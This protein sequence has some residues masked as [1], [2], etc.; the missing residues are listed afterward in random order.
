MK[1]LIVEG[2]T[3]ETRVQ[4]KAFGIKPYHLIFKEMLHLLLPKVQTEVVFPADGSKDLPT[5]KQL[6]KYD[7]ILWTGS[8]LSVTDNIPSVTGQ[9]NLAE[10]IFESGIPLYGSC[11][12]LQ[13]ATTV[14]G[15][16]VARSNKG[17]EFG[18]AKDITLTE[19]ASKSPFFSRRKSGYSALCIHFDE[20]VKTPKN[21]LVLA[22]N[23]HSKVQA[24]AFDYKKSSFFGV[25]YHPEL[26]TSDLA[27]IASLLS[28]KL[29][30]SGRFASGAEVE[31]FVARLSVGKDLP[32][33][34]VDY[35]LHTQ[36]IKAWLEHLS[37]NN[38]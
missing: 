4:R 17:L 7:G 36:E 15:G 9:L 1:L 12:G 24:L 5:S 38:P 19:A 34:I 2:N 6:T 18:M 23:S 14:A 32:K 21:A 28:E 27:K 29:I 13:V 10:T 33:E 11:W 8:A 31:E 3:E 30:D 22:Y 37:L 20:V 16:E 25:Q 26:K 35:Q